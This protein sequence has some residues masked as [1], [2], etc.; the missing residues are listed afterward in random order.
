[1]VQEA[2]AS[3]QTACL[4]VAAVTTRGAFGVKNGAELLKAIELVPA[5]ATTAKTRREPVV[6]A[7]VG[8]LKN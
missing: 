6:T 3:A 4:R 8:L 1:M 2:V 7:L 5:V